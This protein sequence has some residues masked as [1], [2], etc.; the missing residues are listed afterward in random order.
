MSHHL[1][2]ADECAAAPL[3]AVAVVTSELGVL[4]GRRVDGAPLWAFPSGKVERG[5]S[6]DAAAVR[7]VLEET[8][9]RVRPAGVLGQ[10]V[11]PQTG[12]SLVYVAA[13]PVH[14]T[15]VRVAAPAELAEVCWASLARAV[16]VESSGGGETGRGVRRRGA[17]GGG[18]VG[19]TTTGTG[20]G[21]GFGAGTG[22][23]TGA[24]LDPAA[25][26]RCMEITRSQVPV[27][28]TRISA[29]AR[30][31]DPIPGRGRVMKPGL[32]ASGPWLNN[33]TPP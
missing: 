31:S 11:H 1:L 22:D 30:S 4:V 19:T 28:Q 23:A 17:G 29:T 16:F 12:R 15:A 26:R 6:P 13:E 7:E 24:G 32:P 25:P 21:A 33:P 10:R 9:L 3:V 18:G 2:M 20:S 8:G 14:G 27:R 5:E